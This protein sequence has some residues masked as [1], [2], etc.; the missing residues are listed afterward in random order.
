M[1]NLQNRISLSKDSKL[2]LKEFLKN[3]AGVLDSKSWTLIH[4][5]VK[6]DISSKLLYN[7][8]LRCAYCQR[9]LYSTV[10]QIDHFAHKAA[11]PQFT[12]ITTNL[13]YACNYCNSS[14]IKGQKNTIA[15]LDNRYDRTKFNIL[16]PYYDDIDSEIIYSDSDK[17]IFERANCS[18]K[19][20]ATINFFDFDGLPMTLFRSNTLLQERR[21][22]LLLEDERELINRCI[23]YKAK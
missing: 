7:Q 10:P 16:H 20:L 13:F 6:N 2:K 17:I 21:N 22:P 3:K 18:A 19:G 14:G 23:A 11:Y 4:S 8:N 15:V 9:Y 1:L 5:R 12:F